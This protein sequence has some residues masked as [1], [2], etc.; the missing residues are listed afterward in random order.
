MGGAEPRH[1]RPRGLPK[2]L[3]FRQTSEKPGEARRQALTEAYRTPVS[4]VNV[5]WNRAPLSENHFIPPFQENMGPHGSWLLKVIP[6]ELPPV[7]Q[8]AERV[9]QG[10]GNDA[11]S[12]EATSNQTD[13]AVQHARLSALLF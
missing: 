4:P 7:I 6:A 13:N 9:H 5:P 2:P 3:E 11:G 8:K 10:S 12:L 1:K